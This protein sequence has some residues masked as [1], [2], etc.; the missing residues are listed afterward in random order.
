MRYKLGP[1]RLAYHHTD[2]IDATNALLGSSSDG[3][4]D[5]KEDGIPNPNTG[6]TREKAFTFYDGE[7]DREVIDYSKYSLGDV[8]SSEFPATAW[9]ND[10][11][12]LNHFLDASMKLVDRTIAGIIE[13]YGGD[14]SIW[15]IAKITPSDIP[16]ETKR[17]KKYKG[18]NGGGPAQK[19]P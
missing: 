15:K 14:K 12:Y 16:N 19:A 17:T 18:E 11:V 10:A 2:N 9:Q 13:E 4:S 8:P 1:L 7:P 6:E 5:G 3:I